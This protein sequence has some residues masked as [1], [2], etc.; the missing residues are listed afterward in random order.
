[1]SREDL[2]HFYNDGFGW[3]CKK[4]TTAAKPGKDPV[5]R[6]LSEGEAEGRSPELSTRALAKWADEERTELE[7]PQCG[8]RERFK[9][10]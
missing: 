7:C 2:E 5:S 9:E 10:R 1:M 6:L 4:C 8:T 3:V